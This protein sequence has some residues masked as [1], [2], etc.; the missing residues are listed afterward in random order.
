MLAYLAFMVY[1][2][3][4]PDKGGRGIGSIWFRSLAIW[5]YFAAYFP[6]DLVRTVELRPDRNYMFALFPHGVISYGAFA[7]F[8]FE[9]ERWN[10]LFP[11]MRSK[12]MTLGYHFRVPLMREGFLAWGMSSASASSVHS[13]LSASCSPE[14]PQNQR[15]GRTSNAAMLVIGGAEEAAYAR[16]GN[17]TVVLSRRRGFVRLAM[18]TGSPLVPVIS[19]NEVDI[20]DQVANPPG[21]WT[22]TYQDF[23]KR[24][25]GVM[26]VFVVGRGVFQYT[27]GLLPLRKRITTVVGAPLEVPHVAKPDKEQLD[28]QHA[29]FCAA[30]LELFE[31]HKGKYIENAESTHMQIV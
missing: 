17:Y 31:T 27:F 7:N 6:V 13:L 25:T 12:L 14:A 9:N 28:V 29:K 1:D 2:W 8:N 15:D 21:S 30:L 3:Q 23:F 4:T 11:G 16:P 24:W 19:F 18:Q 26:P 5:R 10:K 20:Y 22:R